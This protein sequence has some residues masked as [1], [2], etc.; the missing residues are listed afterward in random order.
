[1]GLTR[2]HSSRSADHACVVDDAPESP[3]RLG[4]CCCWARVSTEN[5]GKL[6]PPSHPLHAVVPTGQAALRRARTAAIVAPMAEGFGATVMPAS[7]RILTFSYA[8]SPKAETN[9]PACPILRPF[10]VDRPAI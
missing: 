10:G 8:L 2:P 4:S 6:F 9:A 7:L 3:R 1:M 5:G